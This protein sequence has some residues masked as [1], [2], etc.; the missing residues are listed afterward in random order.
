MTLKDSTISTSLGL[1]GILFPALLIQHATGYAA[2]SIVF[3]G[4]LIA[5]FTGII[6][7]SWSTQCPECSNPVE[8][9]PPCPECGF[10][11]LPATGFHAM[12]CSRWMTGIET[13]P[14][15]HDGR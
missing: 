9:P 10:P 2:P 12:N 14:E 8:V 7:G 6:F 13:H 5:S 15:T 4:V 3:L 11:D 1:A